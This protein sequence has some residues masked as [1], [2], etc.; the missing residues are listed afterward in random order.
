MLVTRRLVGALGVALTLT[1]NSWRAVPATF[2]TRA[3]YFPPSSFS[4]P[5]MVS[6][7]KVSPLSI[8]TC[9]GSPERG[10]PF[11]SQVMR[12]AGLLMKLMGSTRE[13][14]ALIDWLEA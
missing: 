2:S 12:G 6:V 3:S 11:L 4:I 5:R 9:P 1:Q 14:P 8:R 7:E 13:D 10:T